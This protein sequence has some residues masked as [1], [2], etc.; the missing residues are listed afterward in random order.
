MEGCETN[1]KGFKE[2][3]EICGQIKTVT[4]LFDRMGGGRFFNENR[5]GEHV[6]YTYPELIQKFTETGSMHNKKAT[7]SSKS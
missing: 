3:Q 7:I 4:P 1:G 5:P 2:V 6:P